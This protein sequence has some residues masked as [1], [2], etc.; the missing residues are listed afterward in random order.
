MTIPLH[1]RGLLFP[2]TIADRLDR[3]RAS[4]LVPEDEVPNLWQVQLGIL[5]MG[6]RVLFRP[7]SIGQSKTFPVR[8]TWRARLLERRPLRFPFLLRERAVHPLDFSGLAS[9]PDRIRRHLLGAHHDGVQFL[10]DLQLLHMHDGDASLHQVR[11]AAR[12]VVE[13]RHPRGEW[14]RD[15]VVF[16]RY[17]EALLAAVEAFLEGS[18]E[19][20]ASERADP[21]IDFVAYVRF[22]ARQPATPAATLR[23]LREGRYTVADG[24]TA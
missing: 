3:L 1:A 4:G 8:R 19:A 6:H 5:R 16:E 9:S 20:S 14:L 2:R 13:G 15:L 12:A 17:H 10:Y 11:D 23:A 24:V 22:C 18:F 21:D 7:E